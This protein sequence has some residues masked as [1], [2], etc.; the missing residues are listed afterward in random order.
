[1]K[2]GEHLTVGKF[3]FE[4][5]EERDVEFR[6]NCSMERARTLI[7]S[8]GKAEVESMLEED[9]GAVMT[10]GFCGEIYQLDEDDL[11][12]LIAAS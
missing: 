6:C 3:E 4:V 7:A 2:P 1:M 8:L 12:E 10:C 5:L 11:R 9:H